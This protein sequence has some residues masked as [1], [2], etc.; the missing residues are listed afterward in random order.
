MPRKKYA[1]EEIVAKLRQVDVLV[2][3]GQNIADAI[4]QIGV[5]EVTYYR[6]RREYRGPKTER[7]KHLKVLETENT[8]LRKA[9][10]GLTLDKL[11]DAPPPVQTGRD[12]DIAGYQFMTRNRPKRSARV[13]S[14]DLLAFGTGKMQ[15]RRI[16]RAFYLARENQELARI[17]WTAII[18][19][20]HIYQRKYK[21][22]KILTLIPTQ[23]RRA[24]VTNI[25]PALD[26][27]SACYRTRALVLTYCLMGL[28]IFIIATMDR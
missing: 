18:L 5:S 26:H 4:R 8:R 2:S 6:W 17:E 3:Q 15:P 25:A 9:V 16:D 12:A 28:P 14:D 11:T 24:F 10:S 22:N 19:M 1:P 27:K 13:Q 7:V 21:Q 20:A 23:D